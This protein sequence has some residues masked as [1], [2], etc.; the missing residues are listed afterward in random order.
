MGF[1]TTPGSV[2]MMAVGPQEAATPG[3]IHISLSVL[4]SP[5]GP[6]HDQHRKLAAERPR[7]FLKGIDRWRALPQF[8][9][10]EHRPADPGA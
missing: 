9:L 8:N 2:L 10:A 3:G 7:N 6:V 5:G 4:P 1:R